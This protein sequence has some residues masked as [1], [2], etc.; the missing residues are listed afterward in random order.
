MTRRAASWVSA[1]NAWGLS[2][3][4]SIGGSGGNPGAALT[5]YAFHLIIAGEPLLFVEGE[6]DCWLMHTLGIPAVTALR[7]AETAPAFEAIDQL[8]AAAPSVVFVAYDTDDAGRRGAITAVRAFRDAGL[9]A[10]ALALPSWLPERGDLSDLYAALGYDRG[11]FIEAIRGLDRL[12]IPAPE[13]PPEPRRY[14]RPMD[15]PAPWEAFNAANDIITVAERRGPVRRAGRLAVM[16]CPFHADTS[17]SLYLYR[18]DGHFHCFSCGAHGDAYDLDR[19]RCR[20][21]GREV[22]A[23]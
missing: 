11:A 13:P 1:S 23:A 17:P 20:R 22:W 14:E 15:G 2:G 3:L 9:T 4:T 18:D 16:L 19:G 21:D 8:I 5:L 7:G 6:P 10:D 12:P